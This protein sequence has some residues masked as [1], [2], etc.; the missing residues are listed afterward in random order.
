MAEAETEKAGAQ[1]TAKRDNE[2]AK[3]KANSEA[4]RRAHKSLQATPVI[5][6]DGCEGHWAQAVNGAFILSATFDDEP[7]AF[8]KVLGPGIWMYMATDSTWRISGDQHKRK[9]ASGAFDGFAR[10]LVV[11]AGVLPD[12]T[13][14]W[15]I[16]QTARVYK[17]QKLQMTRVKASSV[18]LQIPKNLS[19]DAW[20]MAHVELQD[21]PAVDVRGA[22]GEFGPLINGRYALA[23]GPK[24]AP[25]VFRKKEGGEQFMWCSPEDQKWHIGE[26]TDLVKKTATSYAITAP[27]RRGGFRLPDE[28]DWRV[29]NGTSMMFFENWEKQPNFAVASSSVYDHVTAIMN[30]KVRQETLP[31]MPAGLLAGLQV[32]PKAGAVEK[33]ASAKASPDGSKRKKGGLEDEEGGD[34]WDVGYKPLGKFATQFKPTKKPDAY[35]KEEC[36][37]VEEIKRQCTPILDLLCKSCWEVVSEKVEED[38]V[39]ESYPGLTADMCF[40]IVAFTLEVGF[41]ME[42]EGMEYPGFECEFY[43]Q[44]NQALR[45]RSP[46]VMKHLAGY[47]HYLFKGLQI[48][49]NFEGTLW[50]GIWDENAVKMTVDNYKPRMREVHWSSFSSATP[51]REIAASFAGDEGLVFKIEM[52]SSARDIR[53]LSALDEDERLILPNTKFVVDKVAHKTKDGVWEIHLVESPGSYTF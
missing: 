22:T 45:K 23:R 6:I 19:I 18:R 14:D 52:H 32:A 4:W 34:A 33:K 40:A 27:D 11:Q 41:I 16:S 10:S 35:L 5:R 26:I 17:P 39:L 49:P 44:Y 13:S 29:K 37:N 12:T 31:Q 51:D 43:R 2:R 38:K 15:E 3:K 50:R 36:C 21:R 20:K 42:D 47:S 24:D 1:T 48:L 25:P 28:G 7:P 53:F 46:N 30:K 8:Q 9:R